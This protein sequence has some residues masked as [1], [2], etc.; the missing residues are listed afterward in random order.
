MSVQRAVH[1]TVCVPA[2]LVQKPM[3]G[4]GVDFLLGLALPEAVPVSVLNHRY[5]LTSFWC[6]YLG[7]SVSCGV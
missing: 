5:H 3:G 1:T 7:L 2:V 4:V 6:W